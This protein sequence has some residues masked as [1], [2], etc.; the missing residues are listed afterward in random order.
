MLTSSTYKGERLYGKKSQHL[1]EPVVSP[2]P[3]IV[4]PE[5]W[6][7]A[8]EQLRRNRRTG[9]SRNAVYLLRGLLVCGLCGCRFQG[10]QTEGRR[11]YICAGKRGRVGR[12]EGRCWAKNLNANQVDAEVWTRLEGFLHDPGEALEQLAAESQAEDA[13]AAR[14]ETELTRLRQGLE[15]KEDER[16]R[17][18]ALYRRGRID[19]GDLDRQLDQ[20]AAEETDLRGQVRT[21]QETLRKTRGQAELQAGAAEL[22]D[23]LR[24]ELREGLDFPDRLE[25]VRALCERID[26][27][28]IGEGDEKTAVLH[29]RYR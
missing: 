16:A 17:V 9:E 3:P 21:A 2:V 4:T 28:T 5:E 27:E 6:E 20:I 19:E 25:V 22:L 29:L 15:E 24:A 18:L 13:A 11:Y 23:R 10:W 12:L 1:R 7:W 26:V 8:R 14:W